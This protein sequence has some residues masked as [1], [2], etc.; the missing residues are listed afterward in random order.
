MCKERASKYRPQANST[1]IGIFVKIVKHVLAQYFL[2]MTHCL[3]RKLYM[4]RPHKY[5]F[6]P[7]AK[8]TPTHIPPTHHLPPIQCR[9]ASPRVLRGSR[10][11][12]LR[13]RVLMFSHCGLLQVCVCGPY[14]LHL[15]SARWGNGQ[16]WA[17][18]TPT[19]HFTD[20]ISSN[21]T[22]M[23][24]RTSASTEISYEI[25]CSRTKFHMK[26]QKRQPG[27]YEPVKRKPGSYEPG[28]R[29]TG[30]I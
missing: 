18:I 3:L 16:L 21:T 13:A 26:S 29:K 5:V 19:K 30:F 6:T 17:T 15:I 25:V 27:S 22:L 23:R 8:P 7:A 12:R 1:L 28:K 20:H 9:D 2:N 24:G 10:D 4:T 11:P 14:G